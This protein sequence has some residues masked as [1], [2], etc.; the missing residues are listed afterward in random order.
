ME[1]IILQPPCIPYF[2]D[3]K[4]RNFQYEIRI[5]QKIIIKAH[6]S[7]FSQLFDSYLLIFLSSKG[8]KTLFIGPKKFVFL[9]CQLKKKNQP[10]LSNNSLKNVRNI[11]NG[12][13]NW[14]IIFCQVFSTSAF[15]M[16]HWDFLTLITRFL[17]I[18]KN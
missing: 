12:Q 18:K 2:K 10:K 11:I 5:C 6:L 8:K 13:K 1:K 15:S 7:F 9:V 3:L 17:Y 14:A 4:M 16:P